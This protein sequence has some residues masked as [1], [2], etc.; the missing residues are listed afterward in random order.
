MSVLQRCIRCDQML[1][2]PERREGG[3]FRC[4]RCGAANVLATRSGELSL[5]APGF[6]TAFAEAFA[7]PPPELLKAARSRVVLLCDMSGSMDERLDK[8]HTRFDKLRQA[9][10]TLLVRWKDGVVVAF[11]S[12]PWL[13]RNVRELGSPH[14]GTNLAL[15][16]NVLAAAQPV[17]TVVL[18]DGEPDNCDA[19]FEAAQQ[20]LGPIDV[21]YC[22]DPQNVSATRFLQSL[23]RE[24]RGLYVVEDLRA[25]ATQLPATVMKLLSS[26]RPAA[27]RP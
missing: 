7:A 15:A 17:H 24:R 10:A 20:L 25:P 9:V 1:R 23:A 14:G 22:G 5:S 26:P 19:A 12:Q 6:M 18:S 2:L 16:F 13:V 8:M 27:P 4:P 21:I 11:N 3:R